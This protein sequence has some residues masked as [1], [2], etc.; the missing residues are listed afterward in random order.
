MLVKIVK[1]IGFC[2]YI[3]SYLL[4]SPVIVSTDISM[5]VDGDADRGVYI[6]HIG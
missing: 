1:Y 4:W 5:E 3:R 2:G 6:F